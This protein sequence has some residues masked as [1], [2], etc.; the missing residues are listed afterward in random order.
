MG[1]DVTVISHSP[2][3]AEDALKMGAKEFIATKEQPEWY[4]RFRTS[5]KVSSCS[6][7]HRIGLY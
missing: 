7:S 5:E 6:C 4:K 1:A 3:K 2:K